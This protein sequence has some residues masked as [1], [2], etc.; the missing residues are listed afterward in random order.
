MDRPTRANLKKPSMC[1]IL[2]FSLPVGENHIPSRS[3]SAFFPKAHHFVVRGGNFTNINLSVPTI[4]SD[5]RRLPMGDLDLR[6]EIYLDHHS[7]VVYRRGNQ[8]SARRMYS[9]RVRGIDSNMTVAL[10]QGNNAEEREGLQ[11]HLWFRHPNFVQIYVGL[12]PVAVTATA[13]DLRPVEW[14]KKILTGRDGQRHG[15]TGC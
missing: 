11:R 5:F 8:A 14:S 12:P 7:S 13:V 3:P 2:T 1:P 9:T 6:A 15:R 10:Y 4:P